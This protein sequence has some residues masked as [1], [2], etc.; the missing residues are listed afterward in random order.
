MPNHPTHEHCNAWE[1]IYSMGLEVH[2]IRRVG[3]LKLKIN[4]IRNKRYEY[5]H[6]SIVVGIAIVPKIIHNVAGLVSID[7]ADALVECVH[8]SL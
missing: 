3:D 8:N 7:V 6:I 4:S 1:Y 5:D 2:S